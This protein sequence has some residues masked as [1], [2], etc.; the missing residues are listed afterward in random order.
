MSQPPIGPSQAYQQ[1]LAR[2]QAE[3]PLPPMPPVTSVTKVNNNGRR[4]LANVQAK[5][6]FTV[7]CANAAAAKTVT[8]AKKVI[9]QQAGAV[10]KASG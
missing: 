4:L 2:L 3:N 7:T 9:Q 10:A 5:I 6:S 8:A 1:Y